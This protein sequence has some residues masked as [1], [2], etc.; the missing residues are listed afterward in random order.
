MTI[1]SPF[2]SIHPV[3][4][5]ARWCAQDLQDE[6]VGGEA[7]EIVAPSITHFIKEISVLDFIE[8]IE[9]DKDTHEKIVVYLKDEVD[10]AEGKIQLMN[11]LAK[12]KIA[13]RNFNY[14]KPSLEQVYLKYVVEEDKQ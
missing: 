7:I 6:L 1:I 8:K 13:V 11:L 4:K 2:N 10:L 14:L 5:G 9:A 3:L 12:N